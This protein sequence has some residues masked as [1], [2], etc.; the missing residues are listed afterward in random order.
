MADT[1]SPES[2]S[3]RMRLI[4]ARDTRPELSVRKILR[5]LS[6]PGYRLHRKDLPGKPDIAYLGRR[7][8]IFVHG[9]FWHGH[10]CKSGKRR[11]KSNQNY[12]LPKI[13]RNRLRDAQHL[14]ELDRLGWSVLTVW[15]CELRDQAALSAKLAAFMA[16]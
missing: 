6:F 4:K 8:A 10:D 11:P 13:D 7:K 1:L 2:R 14:A 15:E 12:W 3:E 9:C 5:S 16:S